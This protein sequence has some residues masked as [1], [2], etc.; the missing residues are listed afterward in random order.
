MIKICLY[1]PLTRSFFNCYLQLILLKL[2]EKL[3]TYRNHKT[4]KK[5]DKS[6]F[7]S[8]ATM[9]LAIFKSNSTFGMLSGEDLWQE[10]FINK[11]TTKLQVLEKGSNQF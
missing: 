1:F 8:R 11:K 9:M 5:C 2:R 7:F 6:S 10:F 4:V 3:F